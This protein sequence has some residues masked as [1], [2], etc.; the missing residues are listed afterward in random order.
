[1]DN[2]AI[3]QMESIERDNYNDGVH[4]YENAKNGLHHPRYSFVTAPIFPYLL[5]N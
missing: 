3:R 5:L 2:Y 1:M 4:L